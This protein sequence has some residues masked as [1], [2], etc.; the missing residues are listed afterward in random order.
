M[1]YVKVGVEC[2]YVGKNTRMQARYFGSKGTNWLSEKSFTRRTRVP[3]KCLVSDLQV[4]DCHA[5]MAS[6]FDPKNQKGSC[7]HLRLV[8]EEGPSAHYLSGHYV[9]EQ[10]GLHFDRPPVKQ[11]PSET[12]QESPP[13]Q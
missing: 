12:T 2:G 7:P 10:C 3:T 6:S 1:G 9:C 11:Q 13:G 8:L 5:L 4:C